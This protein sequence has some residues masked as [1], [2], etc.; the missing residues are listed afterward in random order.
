MTGYPHKQLF[1]SNHHPY[2]YQARSRFRFG[3]LHLYTNTSIDRMIHFESTVIC[4]KKFTKGVRNLSEIGR[5]KEWKRQVGHANP[6]C[7]KS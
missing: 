7:C 2:W 4:S 6:Y 3:D 1:A 5:V